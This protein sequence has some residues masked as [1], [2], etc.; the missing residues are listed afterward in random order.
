MRGLIAAGTLI[1]LTFLNATVTW[2]ASGTTPTRV[3]VLEVGDSLPELRLREAPCQ[4]VVAFLST[5]PFCGA[6]AQRERRSG[7]AIMP[8]TWVAPADDLRAR[9]YREKI[10]PD[11]EL[12]VSDSVYSLM[13]I[14]AVPAGIVVDADGI[15]RRV[16]AY[17]GDKSVD[18]LTCS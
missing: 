15:V 3:S 12:I 17:R 1:G 16:G 14:E 10:H 13:R 9:T 8:T 5:C 11:S 7:G 6:A 18:D 2:R 4:V